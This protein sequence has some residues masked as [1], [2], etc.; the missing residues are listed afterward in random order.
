[1]NYLHGSGL[2]K[3]EISPVACNQQTLIRRSL[4]IHCPTVKA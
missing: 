2:D 1:M 3:K 4:H